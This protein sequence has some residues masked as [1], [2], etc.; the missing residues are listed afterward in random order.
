MAC[1]ALAA[2]YPDGLL[3]HRTV[4][5]LALMLF[6]SLQPLHQMSRH[7]RFLLECAGMLH[8]IGWLDGAKRHNA[9]S[10]RRIFSDETLS[11]DLADRSMI[12]LVARAHR[13]QVRIETHP[14]FPLLAPELRK[15]TLQLAAILRIVDG[16]DFLH[17]GSVQEIHCVIGNREVVCDV[18]SPVDVTQEKERARS[19]SG[20]FVRMFER[21]LV[22]R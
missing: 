11:F 18:I 9:R 17:K 20:L 1:E 21:G 7:D 5:R 13:G 15:K 16:L 2:T 22:I 6:D 8:D 14:L 4:T 10:S 3:H 12:G 19:K